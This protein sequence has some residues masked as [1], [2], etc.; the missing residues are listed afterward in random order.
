ML[1]PQQVANDVDD[2]VVAS[3]YADDAAN[4]VADDVDDVVA[5]A[6]VEPTLPSPIPTTTPLP[7]QQEIALVDRVAVS[8]GSLITT[9][10]L[11]LAALGAAII[12]ATIMRVVAAVT[13][14]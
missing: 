6:D 12:V 8:S 5:H 14:S 11:L 3:V 4:V 2:V 9:P 7:S 13:T 1:V 10:F